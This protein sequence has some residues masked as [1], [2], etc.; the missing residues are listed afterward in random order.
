L[1]LLVPLAL[2]FA[3]E[4]LQTM[5]FDVL[6]LR[7]VPEGAVPP[8]CGSYTATEVC[9]QLLEG[10]M[11]YAAFWLLNVVVAL[12]AIGIA[13]SVLYNILE[14]LRV[15]FFSA[16]AAS[17]VVGTA[18]CVVSGFLWPLFVWSMYGW[19]N[20]YHQV[21]QAALGD[22]LMLVP[23]F[24]WHSR[25]LDYSLYVTTGLL[26]VAGTFI[27][28]GCA[29]TCQNLPS[30]PANGAENSSGPPTMALLSDRL[31]ALKRVTVAGALL[32][33]TG[34]L[35]EQFY[36]QLPCPFLHHATELMGGQGSAGK[37]GA[38]A[39]FGAPIVRLATA[40]PN[41]GNA[42]KSFTDGL[43]AIQGIEFTLMLLGAFSVPALVIRHRAVRIAKLTAPKLT[44]PVAAS[45]Y[46]QDSGFAFA[47]PSYLIDMATIA[48]PAIVGSLS[49][50]IR[51]ASSAS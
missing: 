23:P 16:V 47:L 29:V 46:V 15:S 10:E 49:P 8:S 20:K 18:I 28:V 34:V 5:M 32:L 21:Y 48:M 40:G 24:M 30:D 19:S 7:F 38:Q 41:G 50:L 14:P 11:L 35:Q 17:L 13:T 27:A 43:T 45:K 22:L 25:L 26:A 37:E 51:V 9:A 1:L 2:F 42:Y 12:T 33:V 6:N 31:Q 36:L 3:G 44:P 39:A 4:A